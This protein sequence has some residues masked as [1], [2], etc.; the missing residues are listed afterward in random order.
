MGS[1]EGRSD[2]ETNEPSGT[3]EVV[4]RCLLLGIGRIPS[5]SILHPA[6]LYYRVEE[7]LFCPKES[8]LLSSDL[9]GPRATSADSPACPVRVHDVTAYDKLR[10]KRP[11]WRQRPTKRQKRPVDSLVLN[12]EPQHT[13]GFLH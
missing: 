9:P 12:G 1:C 7:A 8:R 4:R 11:R 2:R 5:G 10:T 3:A 13:A 6:S